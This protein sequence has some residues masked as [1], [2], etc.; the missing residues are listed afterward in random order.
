MD[1]SYLILKDSSGKDEEYPLKTQITLG[2]SNA[3]VI[4]LPQPY[5]S[6]QHAAVYLVN[7]HF[8]IEDLDSRNGTFVNGRRIKKKRLSSGDRIQIGKSIL[9]FV[10]EDIHT[11]QAS[12]VD[13]DEGTPEEASVIQ[14]PSLERSFSAVQ[15]YLSSHDDL[16]SKTISLL[17]NAENSVHFALHILNE[18]TIL[19]KLFEIE[20]NGIAVTGIFSFEQLATMPD[21]LVDSLLGGLDIGVPQ[22]SDPVLLHNFIIIDER[23]V[24]FGSFN[25]M[26]HATASSNQNLL[27]LED[28]LSAQSLLDEFKRLWGG[29][30]VHGGSELYSIERHPEGYEHYL[31]QGPESV[32]NFERADDMKSYIEKLLAHGRKVEAVNLI[33]GW[34]RRGYEAPEADHPMDEEPDSE[35]KAAGMMESKALPDSPRMDPD[36]A[37]EESVAY[38]ILSTDQNGI[39]AEDFTDNV[40]D[41]WHARVGQGLTRREFFMMRQTVSNTIKRLFLICCITFVLCLAMVFV[42]PHMVFLSYISF[43]CFVFSFACLY[44]ALIVYNYKLASVSGK[45]GPLFGFLSIL[46]IPAV[47]LY[48]W[49]MRKS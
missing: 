11:G 36:L 48:A 21:V 17:Q 8:F 1:K 33:N 22:P 29:L 15:C 13:H 16:T 40:S 19:E 35:D 5:I 31:S 41:Y 44:V 4:C 34:K 39:A 49:L 47:F 37:T 9:H 6:K 45:S 30:T 20:E 18:T 14:A 12:L 7:D 26:N 10:Q 43:F 25:A 38:G 32:I 2:R 23:V 28:E 42:L 27:V 46:L 3:N 24:I